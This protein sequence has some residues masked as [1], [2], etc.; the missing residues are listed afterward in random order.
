MVLKELQVILPSPHL[1]WSDNSGALAI[2]SN[3]VNHAR[4]KHIEVD[5][6]FVREKVLNQNIQLKHIFTLEQIADIFTKGH[7]AA[8]FSF[9]NDK[10][11]ALPPIS[12]WGGVE[13]EN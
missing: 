3:P 9:L 4:T 10:L 12:L 11:M 2:A 8:R 7:T 5:I 13:G 1:L 6:H